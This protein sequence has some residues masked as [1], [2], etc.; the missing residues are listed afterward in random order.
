M[1]AMWLL[2]RCFVE[3][4]R[5]HLEGRLVIKGMALASLAGT[6]VEGIHSCVTTVHS[7]FVRACKF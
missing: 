2:D 4:D 1:F 6:G 5:G 7:I 3:L